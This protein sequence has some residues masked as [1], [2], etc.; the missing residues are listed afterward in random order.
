MGCDLRNMV[1]VFIDGKESVRSIDSFM[2]SRR[3]GSVPIPVLDVDEVYF[4][5]ES[6]ISHIIPISDMHP[7]H[8]WC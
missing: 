6:G 1:I 4:I 8:G 7:F 2:I 5:D 3:Y